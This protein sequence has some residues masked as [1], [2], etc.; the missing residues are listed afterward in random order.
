MPHAPRSYV[1]DSE[2]HLW[3]F[4]VYLDLNMVK[5]RWT[6]TTSCAT[7]AGRRRSR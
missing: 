5:A 3:N 1:V 7:R 2:T 4:L 6:A